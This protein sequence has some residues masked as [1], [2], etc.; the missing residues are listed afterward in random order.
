M[1]RA[2]NVTRLVPKEQAGLAAS[3]LRLDDEAM[4]EDDATPQSG[5]AMRSAGARSRISRPTGAGASLGA[6]VTPRGES[7]ARQR[8]DASESPEERED[9]SDDARAEPS[10]PRA[11]SRRPVQGE[12]K[13]VDQRREA[14]EPHIARLANLTPPPHIAG[15]TPP[16]SPRTE[17]HAG[18]G[19]SLSAEAKLPAAD[20]RTRWP[21]DLRASRPV[22]TEVLEEANSGTERPAARM[23][24]V[25]S[26][27]TGRGSRAV[28][29][30]HHPGALRTRS[31]GGSDPGVPWT[32]RGAGHPERRPGEI[33]GRGAAG[34]TVDRGG[35]AAESEVDRGSGAAESA[36]D[37]GGGAAGSAVDRGGG[38]AD[39]AGN[40]TPSGLDEQDEPLPALTFQSPPPARGHVTGIAGT[41]TTAVPSMDGSGSPVSPLASLDPA[42]RIVMPAADPG[43]AA[44]PRRSSLQIIEHEL[45]LRRQRAAAADSKGASP[46][47]VVVDAHTLKGSGRGAPSGQAAPAASAAGSVKDSKGGRPEP[48]PLIDRVEVRTQSPLAAAFGG[49]AAPASRRLLVCLCDPDAPGGRWMDAGP[50]VDGDEVDLM[51]SSNL[52]TKISP[53]QLRAANL[54]MPL[55]LRNALLVRDVA[56]YRQSEGARLGGRLGASATCDVLLVPFLPFQYAPISAAAL[57]SSGPTPAAGAPFPGP[58]RLC[59]QFRLILGVAELYRYQELV[60]P[61]GR[62]ARSTANVMDVALRLAQA[63]ETAPLLGPTASTEDAPLAGPMMPEGAA[64]AQAA[65]AWGTRAHGLAVTVATPPE[66]PHW[67][68]GVKSVLASARA[69][70]SEQAQAEARPQ[71]QAQGQAPPQS[72][73]QPYP[74]GS[75]EAKQQAAPRRSA[76]GGSDPVPRHHE[77]R[78]GAGDADADAANDGSASESWSASARAPPRGRQLDAWERKDR[79]ERKRIRPSDRPPASTT[80]SARGV[81]TNTSRIRSTAPAAGRQPAPQRPSVA[82]P[83]TQMAFPERTAG[84]GGPRAGRGGVAPSTPAPER[85]AGGGGPRAGRGG[86]APSTPANPR[87]GPEPPSPRPLGL[88]SA[89]RPPGL[90]T[91]ARP[92]GDPA[93]RPAL[94]GRPEARPPSPGPTTRFFQ[95]LRAA[96]K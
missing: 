38:A 48:R 8:G 31:S 27:H 49:G 19:A 40:E 55:S 18:G 50:A 21:P 70:R 79:H 46:P 81:A 92:H 6:R 23:E 43:S 64:S 84:G 20:S 24:T 12:S 72:H 93:H 45:A 44:V 77:R 47:L 75:A 26:V 42:A 61:L 74:P 53:A 56:L 59:E 94:A 91:A 14:V 15:L 30:D 96:P 86:V 7:A 68:H 65:G 28:T 85:T 82:Y 33:F 83:R 51:A 60:L 39:S 22:W 17:S 1:S 57:P 66:M 71:S 35:G 52:W 4:S 73:P 54:P 63:C 90:S 69:R 78:R 80:A 41:T 32:A 3:C 16:D 29:G 13:R 10:S 88:S 11:H 9:T 5:S 58:Q 87:Q 67:H 89:A 34:R 62:W 36:V 95:R 37:R 25:R 2:R 76:A